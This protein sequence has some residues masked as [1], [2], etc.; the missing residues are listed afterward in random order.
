MQYRAWSGQA[1]TWGDH[2]IYDHFIPPDVRMGPLEHL[3]F[4][5]EC[6]EWHMVR[7]SGT[8]VFHLCV[9]N[10]PK[11]ELPRERLCQRF[12]HRRLLRRYRPHS[13]VNCSTLCEQTTGYQPSISQVSLFTRPAPFQRRYMRTNLCL[14]MQVA[15]LQR[16]SKKCSFR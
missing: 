13:A 6:L 16:W 11:A 1:D 8:S 5:F 4:W 14:E 15:S 3:F 12:L 7:D 2:A 10:C 9:G